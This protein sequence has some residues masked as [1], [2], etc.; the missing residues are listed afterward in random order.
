MLRPRRCAV[1]L[2][3]A[4]PVLLLVLLLTEEEQGE[5]RARKEKEAR[6]KERRRRGKLGFRDQSRL[7]SDFEG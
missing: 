5:A 4:M 2:W 7:S 6:E 3:D 1:L